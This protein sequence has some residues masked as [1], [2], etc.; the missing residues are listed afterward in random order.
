MCDRRGEVRVVEAEPL[1]QRCEGTEGIWVLPRV[2]E[3][4]EGVWVLPRVCEG[5]GS[6]L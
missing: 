2:C 4:T 3:G 5:M 1:P 6:V